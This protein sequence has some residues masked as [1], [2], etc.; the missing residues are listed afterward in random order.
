MASLVCR[1]P[2]RKHRSLDGCRALLVLLHLALVNVSKAMVIQLGRGGAMGSWGH[3][4][5]AGR[6]AFAARCPAVHLCDEAESDAEA[7]LTSAMW[8]SIGGFESGA[9]VGGIPDDD[10]EQSLRT[11]FGA[12]DT[13]GD[14]RISSNELLEWVTRGWGPNEANEDVAKLVSAADSDGDGFIDYAEFRGA[15]INAVSSPS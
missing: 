3:A 5:G 2:S 4:Q 9:F 14:D 11:A 1:M 13:D 10:Q 6:V 7:M 15:V 8:Q 12:I